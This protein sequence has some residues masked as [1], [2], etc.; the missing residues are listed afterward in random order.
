MEAGLIPIPVFKDVFES[1]FTHDA[2]DI[3]K[4]VRYFS[5]LWKECAAVAKVIKK[6]QVI[7]YPDLHKVLGSDNADLLLY[8][9]GGIP[10]YAWKNVKLHHVDFTQ[11]QVSKVG[12][13]FEY[14][15]VMIVLKLHCI[16]T[17]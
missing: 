1:H 5:P 9:A 6:K 10:E 11:R 14:K 16:Q 15:V 17:V 7:D 8:P 12:L 4:D 13:S 3:M 2:S